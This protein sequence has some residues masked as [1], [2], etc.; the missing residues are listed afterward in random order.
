MVIK[1]IGTDIIEVQRFSQWH[2]YSLQKLKRIFSV[3]EINYCLQIPTN[4]A[5][6]FAVRFA[7]KE[8]MVKALSGMEITLPLLYVFSHVSIVKNEKGKP[9]FLISET[10]KKILPEKI[11]THVSLSHTKEYAVAF[12]VID[13]E[14]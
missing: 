13:Q 6:R 4:S 9:L 1:G 14:Q 3:D 12:V 10:I 5:Q 11:T 8:A 2:T 7:A